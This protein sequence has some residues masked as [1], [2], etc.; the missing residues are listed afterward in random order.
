[1]QKSPVF[2]EFNPKNK[3]IKQILI[4]KYGVK[5]YQMR[6]RTKGS[7]GKIF[8]Y[9]HLTCKDDS[10]ERYNRTL[11]S[12]LERFFTDSKTKRWLDVLPK[13]VANINHSVNRSIGIEPANINFSNAEEIA[14]RLYNKKSSQSC[15]LNVGDTVRIIREKN[16]F[17]KGFTQST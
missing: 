6:G 12:R 14:S 15:S 3:Y 17:S 7:I 11:K 16:I 2:E 13:M 5:M 9:M 8:F 1:M 4:D 10:V